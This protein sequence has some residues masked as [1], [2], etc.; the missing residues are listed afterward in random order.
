MTLA[1]GSFLD[2]C[3]REDGPCAG[4]VPVW[5]AATCGFSAGVSAL[6]SAGGVGPDP[7]GKDAAGGW[8]AD[9]RAI[10][11]FYVLYVKHE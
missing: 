8:P 1:A 4:P 10:N 9:S 3:A 2:R 5:S 11:A 6:C 7:V